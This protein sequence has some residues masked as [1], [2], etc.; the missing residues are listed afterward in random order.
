M[1][2]HP[3]AVAALILASCAAVAT[4]PGPPTPG[5]RRL[6]L[7]HV[8]DTESEIVPAVTQVGGLGRFAALVEA[9]RGREAA[10]TLVLAAGDTFMPAPALQL[11][12][13]GVNAV[14]LAND[15]I[16]L[17]ASALGNH[18]FDRGEAFLAGMVE[19]ASFPYLTST[20]EFRDGPA[21]ALVVRIEPGEPSPWLER[22]AGRILPRGRLCAGTLESTA[23]GDRCRGFTVGVI[24]VTTETLATVASTTL[25]ATSVSTFAELVERVQGE[26]DALAAEGVD[27]VIALS[28]LQGVRRELELVDAGLTGVDV[29]IGGGGD[30]RLANEGDRLHAGDRRA[31]V[32]EGWTPCYPIERRARDGRPVLVLATDGAYRYL[33]RIGLTFDE[34]GVLAG[35]DRDARP[36][37]VDDHSLAE[38]GATAEGPAMELERRVRAALE[39]LS[40]ELASSGVY[41]DGDRENVRNRQTNLGDLSAD[42]IVWAARRG[43]AGAVEPAFALRNGGG[44]RSSIG[45][46]DHD[47]F[48]RGGGPIRLLDVEAALR[49]DNPVVIVTTT[50]RVL[51][52]TLEAA[53]RGVGTSRGHFPQVS[54]EVFLAYDPAGTEQVQEPQTG[55]CAIVRE[56]ERVRTLRVGAIEIVRE[57]RLVTPDAEISF[58]TLD[59]LARGGDGYFPTVAPI[60]DAVPVVD[61]GEPMSEQRALRAYL[62]HLV[63][64]GAWGEGLAYADPA[65]DDPESFTRIRELRPADQ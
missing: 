12:L 43:K 26:A 36:I 3:V 18:E 13:D 11:E 16:G 48:A 41:L 29:I 52:A 25:R 28:H 53:L 39:P 32:C 17:H 49:F 9:I 42:A 1:R 58:A 46:V 40:V 61:G 65:P 8:S 50:H 51:K 59:Y 24:G 62:R 30:D 14:S 33:G 63:E 27:I 2:I 10:P 38:W 60:D 5:E 54:G 64:S 47:T 57:G 19:R 6:V 35:Y 21:K 7:L 23:D 15:A 56:G 4:R 44:I 20:V 34:R 22:S 31:G 55:P 37:P 45:A